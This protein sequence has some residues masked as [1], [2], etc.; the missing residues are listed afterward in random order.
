MTQPAFQLGIK[1]QLLVN[2]GTYNSP[3]WTAISN[4]SDLSLKP[5]WDKAEGSTR[6]SRAKR[7]AKTL[8]DLAISGKI[9]VDHTDTNG[10]VAMLAAIHSDTTMDILCLDG[11]PTDATLTGTLSGYRFDAH[12]LQGEQGQNLG[13]VLFDSFELMPA[14]SANPVNT[15]SVAVTAGSPAYTYTAL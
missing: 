14:L 8:L 9:K 11:N 1:A 15:V 2:T 13:D 10:Y 6:G 4:V 3:T 12:V 5:A 7:Y